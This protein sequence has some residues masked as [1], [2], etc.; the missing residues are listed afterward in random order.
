MNSTHPLTS[1]G[2]PA[3][4]SPAAFTLAAS[5]AGAPPITVQRWI[6]RDG[7]RNSIACVHIDLEPCDWCTR[8]HAVDVLTA[9]DQEGLLCP[10]CCERLR[11]EL[12]TA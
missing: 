9:V 11:E 1:N 4:A 12:L 3:G 6:S 10:P 2:A 7:V 8:P 5:P